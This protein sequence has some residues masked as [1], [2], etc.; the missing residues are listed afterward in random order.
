MKA[1]ES[2]HLV[3]TLS[4]LPKAFPRELCSWGLVRDS[5]GFALTVGIVSLG[6]SVFGLLQHYKSFR[7]KSDSGPKTIGKKVEGAE[8]V[9]FRKAI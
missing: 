7:L 4:A 8:H 2:R 1:P 6:L 3:G 5:L 9:F